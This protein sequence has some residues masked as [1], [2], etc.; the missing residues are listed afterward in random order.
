MV[1]TFNATDEDHN[2]SYPD[3]VYVVDGK[4][5]RYQNHSNLISDPYSD[6]TL[7]H[8]FIG[9]KEVQVPISI[10]MDWMTFLNSTVQISQESF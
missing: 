7:L 8:Q 4:E 5:V 9:A 1:L 2:V 6:G 3:L 10:G